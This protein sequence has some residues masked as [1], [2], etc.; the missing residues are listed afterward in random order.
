MSKVFKVFKVFKVSKV[1]KMSKVSKVSKLSK[2]TKVFNV[3]KFCVTDSKG[4]YFYK[5]LLHT[6]IHTDICGF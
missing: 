4:E 1:F 3:A 2:V 6:Y 5:G